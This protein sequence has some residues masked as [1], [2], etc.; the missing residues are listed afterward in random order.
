MGPKVLK[1]RHCS[2]EHHARPGWLR[3]KKILITS[4]LARPKALVLGDGWRLI[5]Y[6]PF[7]FNVAGVMDLGGRVDFIVRLW[8]GVAV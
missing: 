5:I 6:G 2:P 8:L 7:M 1:D 3:N 4:L